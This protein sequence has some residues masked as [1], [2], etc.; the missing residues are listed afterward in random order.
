MATRISFIDL[1]F[2]YDEADAKLIKALLEDYQIDCTLR[3][4][5]VRK[6]PFTEKEYSEKMI[7]VEEDKVERA[8]KI[9]IDALHKGIISR[10]G[11]FKR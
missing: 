3:P 7:A 4:L 10:R 9:I 6:D 2:L 8:Q 1:Y 5:G 11:D